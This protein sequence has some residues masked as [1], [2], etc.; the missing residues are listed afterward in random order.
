MLSITF[1]LKLLRAKHASIAEGKMR[2]AVVHDQS[3]VTDVAVHIVNEEEL[4]ADALATWSIHCTKL[5]KRGAVIKI[6]Y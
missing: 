4:T 6:K 1:V 5:F 2:V 3:E